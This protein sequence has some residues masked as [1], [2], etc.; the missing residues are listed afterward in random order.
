[1]CQLRIVIG[2]SLLILVAL[3]PAVCLGASVGS[4]GLDP[5][6]K[7][8]PTVGLWTQW[9]GFNQDLYLRHEVQRI[10]GG[11]RQCTAL[12]GEIIA[13]LDEFIAARVSDEELSVGQALVELGRVAR[14][15]AAEDREDVRQA[16]LARMGLPSLMVQQHAVLA[17][18]VLESPASLAPLTELALD[19]PH[20]R[21][22]LAELDSEGSVPEQVRAMAVYSL[23]LIG[24]ANPD[25]NTRARIAAVLWRICELPRRPT[26]D[27]KTAAVLGM[28]LIPMEIGSVDVVWEEPHPF[29]EKARNSSLAP[30]TTRQEQVRYLL[31]FFL[32]D[33]NEN[34]HHLVRAHAPRSLALLVGDVPELKPRVVAA[35]LPYVTKRGSIGQRALRQS[36]SLALG[37]LGDLDDDPDDQAIRAALKAATRNADTMVKSLSMIALGQVGGRPGTGPFALA[38]EQEVRAFLMLHLRKGKTPLKPWA[39]LALGVMERGLLDRGHALVRAGCDE[40]QLALQRSTRELDLGAYAIALGL[41]RDVSAER[42]LLDKLDA[43]QD[44]EA[45][46]YLAIGLALMGARSA[47][48]PLTR[49]MNSPSPDGRLELQA[50]VAL[51]LLSEKGTLS[52]LVTGLEGEPSSRAK[53][54][55]LLCAAAAH[56]RDERLAEPLL[57]ELKSGALP[58]STRSSLVRALGLIA[59]QRSSSW[60][61]K[62]SCGF[63][64]RASTAVLTGTSTG[65]PGL[66]ETPWR[67]TPLLFPSPQPRVRRSYG[68]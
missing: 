62:F 37:M 44:S 33:R 18:G 16:I 35:L 58:E 15:L 27:L 5:N 20:G 7:L 57:R 8:D 12:R 3:V 65:A 68:P 32:D 55:E 26:K 61:A 67:L 49:L 52:E 39:G 53:T 13:A 54:V 9:W 50:S 45:R 25:H 31:D 10:S 42:L 41:A 19:T 43:A 14:A 22:L 63:N 51:S 6:R 46:G 28:G 17:L 1:M 64:Y 47:V 38:G 21:S 48:G 36:A 34:R 59:D 4:P 56:L 2:H 66:I 23:A 40:L 29:I 24:E 60:S 30:P 11:E